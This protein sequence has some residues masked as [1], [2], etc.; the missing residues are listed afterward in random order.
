MIVGNTKVLEEVKTTP[1]ELLLGR[2][3]KTVITSQM[4]SCKFCWVNMV[5]VTFM[6][7]RTSSYML[8]KYEEWFYD[9]NSKGMELFP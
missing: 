7:K 6:T 3:Q 2:I 5:K 9:S 1:P 4:T 8:L